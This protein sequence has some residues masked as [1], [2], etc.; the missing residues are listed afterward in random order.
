LASPQ[1]L[2]R[3]GAAVGQPAALSIFMLSERQLSGSLFY[4]KDSSCLKSM[5]G[6]SRRYEVTSGRSEM[7][8]ICSQRQKFAASRRIPD[9]DTLRGGAMTD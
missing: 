5:T 7:T 4:L 9:F 3:K 2:F 6:L 1:T 8:G